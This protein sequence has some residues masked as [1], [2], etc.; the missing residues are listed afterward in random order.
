M[1]SIPFNALV[2]EVHM[3]KRLFCYTAIALLVVLCLTRC[4]RPSPEAARLLEKAEQLM[5]TDPDSALLLI[6][7]LYYSKEKRSREQS[8]HYIVLRARARHENRLGLTLDTLIFDAARYFVRHDRNPH[9][10]S[11]A[12]LY[13]GYTCYELQQYERADDYFKKSGLP[14]PTDLEELSES[15]GVE[16]QAHPHPLVQPLHTLGPEHDL[17]MLKGMYN[18]RFMRHQR[19]ILKLLIIV[20]VS[21]VVLIT[22]L[23]WMLKAKNA[24]LKMLESINTLRATTSDL[25]EATEDHQQTRESVREGR[26]W[27]FN[28]MK[29][30]MLLQHRLPQKQRVKEQATLGK[31]QKIVFD[32]EQ[33]EPLN[34]FLSTVEECYPGLRVFLDSRH[35]DLTEKECEVCLLTFAGLDVIEI[36][37]LLGQ[38][39]NSIYKIR[40]SLNR[41]IGKNFN[42]ILKEAFEKEE[43]GVTR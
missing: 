13:S 14:Y 27:K 8:M 18:A 3:F 36:A 20:I 16:A 12:Y 35:P 17:R 15:N 22:V 23:A 1:S 34:E 7:S 32:P 37:L 11:L 24:K 26:L 40:S 42:S 4:D 9:L 38:S 2:N 19:L 41:K 21:S 33:P 31:F 39:K 43:M 28:V 25:L 10:T 6:H 30:T 29:E 5:V